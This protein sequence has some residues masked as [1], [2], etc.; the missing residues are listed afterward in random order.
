MSESLPWFL[1]QLK[2]NAHNV[3]LANLKRQRITVF[4]PRLE[5][6]R[7]KGKSLSTALAPLFPG[8]AFAKIDIFSAMLR[9]VNNTLGVTRVVRFGDAFPTPV[10]DDLIRAIEQ[11]CDS[12]GVLRR[13]DRLRPSDRVSVLS[14]P[15]AH[16]VGTVENIGPDERVTVLFSMM[17]RSVNVVVDS[18]SLV[19]MRR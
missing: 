6:P 4:L 1:I 14:G 11:R 10:P 3:A 8:Y 5:L 17:G 15:F 18:R 9:S 2:P 12:E 7:K 16:F 19:R 13:A